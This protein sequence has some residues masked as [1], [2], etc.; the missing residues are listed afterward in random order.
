MI[1]NIKF[2]LRYSTL[3]IIHWFSSIIYMRFLCG[4]NKELFSLGIEDN[5][6][7]VLAYRDGIAINFFI[8]AIV[9][10]VFGC[11]RVYHQLR[12]L[13]YSEL[14]ATEFLVLGSI[15]AITCCVIISIIV[16]ISNPIL[17]AIFIVGLI[18][19]AY[20]GFKS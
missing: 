7:E 8:I 10:V 11:W 5:S 19:T 9:L 13:K 15:V 20:S 6:W 17:K 3:E 1:E 12:K 14:E 2:L 4:F 18:G 16:L